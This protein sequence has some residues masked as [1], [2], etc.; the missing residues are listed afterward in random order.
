[1]SD[2]SHFLFAGCVNEQTLWYQHQ[3]NPSEVHESL[4]NSTK[5]TVWCGV[6][7]PTVTDPCIVRKNNTEL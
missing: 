7:S 5:V 3:A 1:M 2:E 4:S 6:T